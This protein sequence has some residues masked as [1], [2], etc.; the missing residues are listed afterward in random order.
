LVAVGQALRDTVRQY[1]TVYRF[2]G[3]EFVIIVPSCE[4]AFAVNAA[5]RYR[6]AIE[7]LRIPLD[8]GELKIT[9]I[10]RRS[11]HATV[12]SKEERSKSSLCQ[13]RDVDRA[14]VDFGRITSL[15]HL[16][17]LVRERSGES[18]KVKAEQS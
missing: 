14:L 5:E 7:G 8:S 6:R 18:N 16:G 9:A 17:N 1:D 2:G 4:A 13:S 10:I 15:S 12:C 3:E 11:R